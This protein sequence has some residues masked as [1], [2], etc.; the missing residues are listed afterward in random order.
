M[1][2]DVPTSDSAKD[3]RIRIL[4]FQVDQLRAELEALEAKHAEAIYSAAWHFGWPVRIV[5]RALRR[6][7]AKRKNDN[8]ASDDAAA[9]QQ[10]A[11]SPEPLTRE[12]IAARIAERM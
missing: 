3:D 5:E 7:F 8:M 2:R 9:T 12:K 10:A 4:E 6:L 1:D 11:Q